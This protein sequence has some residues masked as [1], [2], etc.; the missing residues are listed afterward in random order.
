MA[1]EVV[2]AEGLATVQDLGRPDWLAFGVPRS[3]AMDGFA[4][5]AANA[6]V[7]NQSEAAGLEIGLGDVT[8]RALQDCL[9]AVTGAGFQLSVYIWDFPLWGSILVRRGWPIRL[10]KIEGGAWTYLAVRG[11]VQTRLALGSR[12]TYLRG[13]L[14]GLEGRRLQAGDLLP[15]AAD[16]GGEERA[17]R[18]LLS[19]VRP[20]YS[21]SPTVE[22]I[23]GPQR[24]GFTPEGIVTFLSGEYHLSLES[25]R[26][27]YRLEGPKLIHRG[28]PDLL[29]EGM[30]AGAV[31]VPAG[32]QPIVMMADSPTTGGYLKIASVVSADL[33]LV[34][35]CAP[36]SGRLRFRETTVESAQRRY[37]QLM[38]GLKNGIVEAEQSGP[39]G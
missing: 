4:L 23:P 11:G 25:D 18:T 31:Q 32:G 9:I 34:A 33:P 39:W 26:M 15:I 17:G 10:T 37:R 38:E 20:A 13:A 12:S 24:E 21:E 2:E 1:L 29:S 14:G 19:Q 16:S 35:Q 30:T 22:V 3:G 27:G 36:G 6:L 28:S 5:R 7:G 8:L